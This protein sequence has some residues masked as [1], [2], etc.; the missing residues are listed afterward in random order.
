MLFVLERQLRRQ[1]TK[2]G[3]LAEHH[4]GLV[5]KQVF[6]Y[7]QFAVLRTVLAFLK[8]QLLLLERQLGTLP[9]NDLSQAGQFGVLLVEH[10]FLFGNL[11]ILKAK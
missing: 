3:V 2:Q 5:A 11:V 6:L 8:G 1:L 4:G 9:P 7:R 10:T